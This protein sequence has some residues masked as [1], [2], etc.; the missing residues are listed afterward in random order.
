MDKYLAQQDQ[1]YHKNQCDTEVVVDLEFQM[2]SSQQDDSLI[3]CR[4][5]KKC[6]DP[7]SIDI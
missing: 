5:L 2:H 6:W 4:A 1:K 7:S 3:F